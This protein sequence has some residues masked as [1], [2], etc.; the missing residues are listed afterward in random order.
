MVPVP[1]KSLE[2]C[3]CVGNCPGHYQ[4]D[5]SIDAVPAPVPSEYLAAQ[6]AINDKAD[7]PRIISMSKD[8][9]LKA[10]DVKFFWDH[11]TNIKR[12]RQRGVEKAKKTRASKNSKR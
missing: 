9:L 10:E 4:K 5:S 6:F 7:M 12:N 2:K 1:I 3:S 11:M 8:C